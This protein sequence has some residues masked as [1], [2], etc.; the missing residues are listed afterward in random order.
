MIKN[1]KIWVAYFI[2]FIGLTLIEY[3]YSYP[4]EGENLIAR[5]TDF[6]CFILLAT[7]LYGYIYS[8]VIFT[9]LI[10]LVLKYMYLFLFVFSISSYGAITKENIIILFATVIFLLPAIIALFKYTMFMNKQKS[11]KK[12]NM[13]SDADA[14]P[15]VN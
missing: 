7:A 8:K 2:F 6:F 3:V 1:N 10:W 12:L 5:S 13:N 9:A 4:Y 11:N 15:P 14:P